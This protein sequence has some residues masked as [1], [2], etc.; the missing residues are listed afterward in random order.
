MVEE[1]KRF[2]WRVLASAG[3]V[4]V[5]A[6]LVGFIETV[7]RQGTIIGRA[8]RLKT[9][10]SRLQVAQILGRADIFRGTDSPIWLDDRDR[11][12]QVAVRFDV[13]DRVVS[14]EIVDDPGWLRPFRFG[15]RRWAENA[16]MN[17][18]G[19]RR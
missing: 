1:K 19:P 13:S 5:L 18:H 16:Y 9:G 11:L 3:L 14:V 7:G 8:E 6:A 4:V 2:S 12:V 15:I 17:I 10:M